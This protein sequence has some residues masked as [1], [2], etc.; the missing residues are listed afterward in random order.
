MPVETNIVIA[1]IAGRYT[2]AALAE[3][4]KTFAAFNGCEK[5]A[6]DELFI[7]ETAKL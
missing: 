1:T 6:G 2:S 4:L 7:F 3:K 5:I